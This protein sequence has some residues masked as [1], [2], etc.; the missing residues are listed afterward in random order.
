MPWRKGEKNKAHG[1]IIGKEHWMKKFL[2]LLLAAFCTLLPT[3]VAFASMTSPMGE[4]IR[5]A[6]PGIA[7]HQDREGLYAA[8]S[9]AAAQPSIETAFLPQSSIVQAVSANTTFIAQHKVAVAVVDDTA[10]AVRSEV[11][12]LA[13]GKVF[14]G[15]SIFFKVIL[16]ANA[17]TFGKSEVMPLAI[18]PAFD[19]VAV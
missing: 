11:M 16:A 4:G 7:V 3:S 14:S 12:P 18:K 9:P 13:A 19:T 8:P 6:P 10:V 15:N 17:P 1:K 5:G 2:Y